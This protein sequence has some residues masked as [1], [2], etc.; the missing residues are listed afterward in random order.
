MDKAEKQA[1]T[2]SIRSHE[3]KTY[4]DKEV[5]KIFDKFHNDYGLIQ[6]EVRHKSLRMKD[7][8]NLKMNRKVLLK[9]HRMPRTSKDY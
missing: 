5:N 6:V 8:K 3:A 4:L 9:R 2:S 7:N 1:E